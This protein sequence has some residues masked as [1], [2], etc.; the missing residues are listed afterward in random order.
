MAY[1]AVGDLGAGLAR[2]LVDPDAADTEGRSDAGEREKA[3]QL[4]GTPGLAIGIGLKA[5]FLGRVL[6]WCRGRRRSEHA[7]GCRWLR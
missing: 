7:P 2:F 4:V 3:V 1:G 5:E 6:P